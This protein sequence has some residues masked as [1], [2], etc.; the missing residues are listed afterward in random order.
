MRSWKFS[1]SFSSVMFFAKGSSV[2]IPEFDSSLSRDANSTASQLKWGT[3]TVLPRNLCGSWRTPPGKNSGDYVHWLGTIIKSIFVPNQEPAFAWPFGNG[4]VRVGTQGLFR[5]C[6]KTFVA[7][8]LL[9][10]LTATRSPKSLRGCVGS[11]G[12]SCLL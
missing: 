2:L 9:A 5:L 11:R 12:L 6:L 3:A 8:F 4:P 7:P 1:I 10:R